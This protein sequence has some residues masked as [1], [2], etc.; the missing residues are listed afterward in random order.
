MGNLGD[1]LWGEPDG[2]LPR[3]RTAHPGVEL[4]AHTA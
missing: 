1:G 4:H 2:A 3:D